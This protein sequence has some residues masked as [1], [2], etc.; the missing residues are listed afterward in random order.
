MS[1]QLDNISCLIQL[2]QK[3]LTFMNKMY[4]SSDNKEPWLFVYN[5]E[6]EKL[7]ILI[8]R[9]NRLRGIIKE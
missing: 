2:K 6:Q 9:L 8:R 5:N 4:F 1:Q 7:K 3:R